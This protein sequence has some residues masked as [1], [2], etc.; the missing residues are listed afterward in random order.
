MPVGRPPKFKKLNVFSRRVNE[1][2]KTAQEPF[3]IAG[4]CLFLGLSYEGLREYE[5][6]EEFSATVKEAKLKI[7]DHINKKG[8]TGAYN[9]N[10]VQFNLK[11]N[12][13]WKD[14]QEIEH[15][16]DYQINFIRK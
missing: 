11:N 10:M 6:K 3:T 2:F 7:E 12:F 9:S 5:A 16:G 15:S 4:L 14:K 8:L 13:G 1:Y